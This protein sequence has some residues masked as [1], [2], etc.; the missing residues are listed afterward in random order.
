MNEIIKELRDLLGEEAIEAAMDYFSH[1]GTFTN[2]VVS[3]EGTI[4]DL[5][6]DPETVIE[7]LLKQLHK[8]IP[9][10]LNEMI[11]LRMLNILSSWD[12]PVPKT[13]LKGV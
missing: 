2:I 12:V 4:Q 10:E 13:L 1:D 3:Q 5:K 7:L 6:L 11:E 8:K 9:S